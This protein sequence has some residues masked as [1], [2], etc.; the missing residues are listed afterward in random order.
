MTKQKI[1]KNLEEAKERMKTNNEL[2]L[3]DAIAIVDALIYIVRGE[4]DNN[5]NVE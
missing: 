5:S 3:P 1:V 2:D 4:E